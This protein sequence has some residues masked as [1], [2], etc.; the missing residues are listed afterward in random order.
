VKHVENAAREDDFP[1]PTAVFLEHFVQTGTGKNLFARIHSD[2]DAARQVHNAV[3][4]SIT[5]RQ[6]RQIHQLRKKKVLLHAS[7]E[8][9][10][11]GD[12]LRAKKS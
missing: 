3:R 5:P 12:R 8:Q 6:W 2:F 11:P 9:A 10:A 7:R 1:P 4:K